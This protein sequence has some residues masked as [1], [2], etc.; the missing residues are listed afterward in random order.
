MAYFSTSGIADNTKAFFSLLRSF[1]VETVG[2]TLHD[3]STL[4]W[5]YAVFETHGETGTEDI[6][7]EVSENSTHRLPIKAH[8]HW[9]KQ[10]HQGVNSAF[11]ASYTYFKTNDSGPFL[12]WLFADLDHWF[13]V[14]KLGSTYYGQYSGIMKRFWSSDIAVCQS[15]MDQGRQVT[16]PVDQLPSQF[17]VGKPLILKDD[18]NISRVVVS[19]LNRTDTPKTVTFE[20][21]PTAFS[22]GSKLGEDPQPTIVSRYSAPGPFYACNHWDGHSSATT[23][24]GDC[25][26]AS[27]N[28]EAYS[29]PDDRYGLFTMFPWLAVQNANNGKELRG[30]L[31]EVYAVGSNNL[32]SEDQIQQNGHSYRVFNL[33]GAGYCAVKE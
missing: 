18:S 19:A 29:S 9:D 22:T 15:D 11:H 1:L 6:Y 2:W 3:A 17:E 20:S 23:Q 26:R 10:T 24:S 4:P 25:L 33:S 28:A 7:L 16:V 13:V 14:T 31:I 12:Y 32:D 5:P 21:L 8:Q 27:G 30:Q